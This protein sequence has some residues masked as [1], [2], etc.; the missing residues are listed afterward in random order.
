MRPDHGHE[1]RRAT[2]AYT[3]FSM[4]LSFL[5]ILIVLFLMI[6]F[7]F[8]GMHAGVPLTG[9]HMQY[10]EAVS[11]LLDLRGWDFD[12]YGPV[13]LSG[14]WEFFWEQL[15]EPEQGPEGERSLITVPGIWGESGEGLASDDRRTGFATYRLTILT[16]P[17]E[18][19]PGLRSLTAGT[20]MQVFIGQDKVISTGQTGESADTSIP[21]YGPEVVLL[22]ESKGSSEL[23]LQIWVSNYDYRIGGLWRP[24]WYGPYGQLSS[25]K[26]HA[27][28]RSIML[29]SSLLMMALYHSALFLMRRKDH[30]FLYL[31]LLCLA[32]AVRSLLPT[33][34]TI[35]RFFPGLP[36][37]LIIRAEY[38]SIIVSMLIVVFLFRSLYPQEFH[39]PVLL[40]SVVA[41]TAF[42]AAVIFTE[43]RIFTHLLFSFY[44]YSFCIMGY[45]LAAD[46]RALVHKRQGALITLIGAVIMVLTAISDN[47]LANFIISSGPFIE[48]GLV[49]FIFFQALALSLRFTGAFNRVEEL[50]ESLQGLNDG[51]ETEIC[52]RSE[53]LQEA[54]E[55]MRSL[56]QIR[57]AELE[58]KRL[59]RN[60][61]DGLGQTI[62]A[63]E[64]LS[65]SLVKKYGRA[66]ETIGT[67]RQLSHDLQHETY[68]II[69]QLYPVSNGGLGFIRAVRTLAEQTERA[70]GVSVTV[71]HTQELL[72]IDEV[73]ANELYYMLKSALHNALRHAGPSWILIRIESSVEDML[74]SIE[75]DGLGS[76]PVQ[77][78]MDEDAHGRGL[79]IMRYRAQTLGGSCSAGVIDDRIFRVGISVPLRDEQTQKVREEW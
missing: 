11:G 39:R 40:L 55:D 29:F 7:Y 52:R 60:L 20:N 58:R 33:E 54:Y 4:L 19:Q 49:L 32:I 59:G 34:Y 68:A 51:L 75:N 62:H 69:E 35:L 15:L 63:L 18:M 14:E 1:R 47:L 22:Q 27:D 57:I 50:S 37:S 21:A 72:T 38:L 3:L 42:A 41:T 71:V 8:D 70:S 2:E 79:Q 44:V 31:S 43:P 10:P 46:I 9:K 25:I 24:L 28:V 36:F 6:S 16:D 48:L 74:L 5:G 56:E 45:L 30:Q 67:V 64:L 78:D 73:T 77:R 12:A 17:S 66:E 13:P 61:H 65:S 26:W 53:E 23:H 76:P